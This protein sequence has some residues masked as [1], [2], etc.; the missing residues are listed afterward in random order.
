MMIACTFSPC[1]RYRYTWEY[2]W[3][4]SLPPCAFIGLNPSTADEEG[5]DPTV[6]R[7]IAYARGWGYGR[8]IMLNL[9]AFR[10]TDPRDMKA[11]DEPVGAPENNGTLREKA[12]YVTMMGGVVVAAWGNHGA[13]QGRSA[14]VRV[15]LAGLPLHYLTMTKSGEPGHPLYLRA[16]LKPRLLHF[17]NVQRLA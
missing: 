3:D 1:R 16:D 8:L 6:R 5:P 2:V 13:H 11:E 17:E 7:C 9:F 15:L 12:G 10:A 14:F 4:R